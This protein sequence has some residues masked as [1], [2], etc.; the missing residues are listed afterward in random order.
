MRPIDAD[1]LA[2]FSCTVPNEYDAKSYIEGVGFALDRIDA[3]PT[4]NA[5]QMAQEIKRYCKEQTKCYKC[6]FF[7]HTIERLCM[8]TMNSDVCPEDWNLP[9]VGEE[10]DDPG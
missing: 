1:K 3:F 10:H 6:V 8:L 5:V 9:E 7:T 4:I 2:C